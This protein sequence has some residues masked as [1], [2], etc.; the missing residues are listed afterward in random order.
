MTIPKLSSEVHNFLCFISASLLVFWGFRAIL[1][2]KNLWQLWHAL[3][4]PRPHVLW[5]NSMGLA[6][7]RDILLSLGGQL[8]SKHL[9]QLLQ[10]ALAQHDVSP[11]FRLQV[12]THVDHSAK[13]TW[14]EGRPMMY[15]P[16]DVQSFQKDTTIT[17]ELFFGVGKMFFTDLN[18]SLDARLELGH[19][20]EAPMIK[21]SASNQRRNSSAGTRQTPRTSLFTSSM[22]KSRKGPLEFNPNMMYPHDCISQTKH[23]FTDS[24]QDF[25]DIVIDLDS[26]CLDNVSP[27]RYFCVAMVSIKDSDQ[28]EYTVFDAN[29][30]NFESLPAYTNSIKIKTQ[31]ILDLEEVVLSEYEGVFGCDSLDVN[32]EDGPECVVCYMNPRGVMLLPCRHLCVCE[33]CLPKIDKC[34]LCRKPMVENVRWKTQSFWASQKRISVQ[35]EERGRDI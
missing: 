1:K 30:E 13:V 14:N 21:R 20:E 19:E 8:Q 24:R 27:V 33:E 26:T 17:V 35:D 29:I 18:Q 31:Y 11:L 34:P 10:S 7:L 12:K 2:L 22:K 32:V 16:V 9:K 5:F 4:Q 3:Q 28:F 6:E 25:E 15:L 23:V